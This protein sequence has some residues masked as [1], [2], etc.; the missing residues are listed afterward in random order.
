MRLEKSKKINNQGG[1]IF[2]G[3]WKKIP[4]TASEYPHLLER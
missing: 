1:M 2:R 3:G 4:K